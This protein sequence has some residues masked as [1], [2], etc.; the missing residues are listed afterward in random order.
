V[1]SVPSSI[2]ADTTY[3]G[4]EAGEPQPT[5]TGCHDLAHSLWYRYQASSAG[6]LG[7]ET[8]ASTDIDTNLAIYS[9]PASGATFA[10]LTQV[11]CNDDKQ[12]GDLLSKATVP[13]T[14]GTTYYVQVGNYTGFGPQA[15]AFQV[16]FFSG[17]TTSLDAS[18][19]GRTVTLATAVA[20]LAGPAHGGSVQF[21]D[22][23]KVK[24]TV[25]LEDD[26]S[27]VLTLAAA[28]PGA[29]SY[30]AVFVPEDGDFTTSE[31]AAKP[32]TVT[33]APP[34]SGA[35]ASSTRLTVPKKVVRGK[36]ATIEVTMSTAAGPATGS[37]LVVLGGKLVTLTLTNGKATLS[38]KLKTPGS[39]SVVAVYAG[40]D[41]ARS[42]TATA[43]IKVKKKPRK[44]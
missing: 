27:A 34:S 19:A 11:G 12:S 30:K 9:G 26:G 40:T 22:G 31:S 28:A 42:S 44:K 41:T 24:G 13:V 4:A 33:D 18:A 1:A 39:V 23:A 8:F 5:G 17:T 37:V 10:G 25:P 2:G 7:V 32:V 38:T 16:H 20:G 43:K 29:H 3:A 14:A 35:A 36:K 6:T 21:F 15:G